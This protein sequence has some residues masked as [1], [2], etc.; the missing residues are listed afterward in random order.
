MQRGQKN[1]LNSIEI[2][3]VRNSNRTNHPGSSTDKKERGEERKGDREK[4]STKK[5]KKK[6]D[7]GHFNQS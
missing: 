3:I 7:L 4:E 5:K 6:K 2:Q 1:T